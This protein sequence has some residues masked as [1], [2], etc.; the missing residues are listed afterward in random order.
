MQ[1]QGPVITVVYDFV[2]V[3]RQNRVYFIWF[4]SG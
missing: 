2:K 4:I 3:P 1:N